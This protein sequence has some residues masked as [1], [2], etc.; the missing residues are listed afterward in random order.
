MQFTIDQ[1]L[2]VQNSSM[3]IALSPT[4]VGKIFHTP[5]QAME[6]DFLKEVSNLIYANNINRLMPKFIR[7][8]SC[9]TYSMIVMERIYAV[10]LGALENR[11]L[12]QMLKKLGADLKELHD[13]G[14]LHNDL[15]IK[16]LRK[17]PTDPLRG[18]NIIPQHWNLFFEI[19]WENKRP[20][21]AHN[22]HR[23]SL[24]LVSR[25]ARPENTQQAHSLF[26][27]ASLATTE[28]TRIHV[29]VSQLPPARKD[30]YPIP[31]TPSEQPPGFEVLTYASTENLCITRDGIRLLDAGRSLLKRDI[32]TEAFE[33]AAAI[34]RYKAGHI[35]N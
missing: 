13:Q 16:H 19:P 26:P 7:T 1:L 35:F 29:D 12:D 14:F 28:S 11:A 23:P 5:T 2:F 31:I 6:S 8:E 27:D 20:A 10:E 25:A 15:D 24:S 9:G 22:T 34:E 32:G 21:N 33:A 30:L 18:L 3:V 4:E 17:L